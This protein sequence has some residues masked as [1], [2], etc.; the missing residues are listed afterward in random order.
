MSQFNTPGKK[1]NAMRFINCSPVDPARFVSAKMIQGAS[2]SQ[3]V[4]AAKFGG[5]DTT[6]HV[7]FYR[8]LDTVYR[9]QSSKDCETEVKSVDPL[10]AEEVEYFATQTLKKQERDQLEPALKEAGFEVIYGGTKGHGWWLRDIGWQT[11]AQ[12]RKLIKEIAACR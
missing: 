12:C 2:V 5:L 11:P 7:D 9:V 4:Q 1:A 10:K 3:D 8:V 6:Y